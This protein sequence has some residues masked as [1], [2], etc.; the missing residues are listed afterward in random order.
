MNC[1]Y[2]SIFI[3][4]LCWFLNVYWCYFCTFSRVVCGTQ[5]INKA[6]VNKTNRLRRF[7]LL[8][9]ALNQNRTKLKIIFACKDLEAGYFP[10]QFLLDLSFFLSLNSALVIYKK[11]SEQMLSR[12]SVDSIRKAFTATQTVD[13]IS[14]M[15]M[16]YHQAKCTTFFS[17]FFFLKL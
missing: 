12:C 7:F 4:I 17:F 16:K 1:F 15:N 6:D 8:N 5:T 11:H 3:Y 13:W 14:V 9:V 10:L 2:T